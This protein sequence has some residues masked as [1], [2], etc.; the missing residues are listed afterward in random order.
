MAI[1]IVI[2]FAV[3][4]FVLHDQFDAAT[5]M[6]T[7][8]DD[9]VT[10]LAWSPQPGGPLFVGTQKGAVFRLPEG[11]APEPVTGRTKRGPI[12]SIFP[13]PS[14]DEAGAVWLDPDAGLEP[15][16]TLYRTDGLPASDGLAVSIGGSIV[17]A[18]ALSDPAAGSGP[19]L[20]TL[21]PDKNGGPAAPRGR[22]PIRPPGAQARLTAMSGFEI[23]SRRF[24][25]VVAGY[26]T[27]DVRVWD[28]QTGEA[29]KLPDAPPG[30]SAGDA[31]VHVAA[32]P[33]LDDSTNF[34]TASGNGSFAFYEARIDAATV[35]K[36][37]SVVVRRANPCRP[38]QLEMR[39]VRSGASPA[40]V[41]VNAA[42]LVVCGDGDVI[43]ARPK[44]IEDG[45]RVHAAQ[46]IV[47]ESFA[48]KDLR[49]VQMALP[50]SGQRILALQ[51]ALD[52][53]GASL[54]PRPTSQ[55]DALLGPR[56]R[57]SVAA[58]SPRGD[59]FAVA[60]NDGVIR[61][62]VL[63]DDP[64]APPSSATTFRISGHADVVTQLAISAD[65]RRLASSGIDGRLWITD[66]D[67]ARRRA[68]LL[69]YDLSSGPVGADMA[70]VPLRVPAGA[71]PAA[72]NDYIVVYASDQNQAAAED[73][74][75]RA[76]R[77][78]FSD[79]TIYRLDDLFV[80]VARFETAQAQA[81]GLARLK[82]LSRHS[83]NAYARR[84]SQWCP[85]AEDAGGM[86]RCIPQ[87]PE[88]TIGNL[89]L[90]QAPPDPA[91][92]ASPGADS[93][94][95]A[96]NVQQS[97]P[98]AASI[99]PIRTDKPADLPRVQKVFIKSLTFDTGWVGGEHSQS[100]ACSQAIRIYQPQFPG[101][102]LESA[103]SSESS[104]KE[105]IGK[106]TYRYVCKFNVF[107]MQA[108]NR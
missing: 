11:G 4:A 53:F 8:E 102:I 97:S 36:L 63:P 67:Q 19:N 104:R 44:L 72:P 1:P 64:A 55:H 43:V 33:P 27:G 96:A 3:K 103:G 85:R 22:T 107:E 50:R 49:A 31:I 94:P 40:P 60:G 76:R 54:V 92:Q 70:A 10:A 28:R 6:L 45:R 41:N 46:S 56:W 21:A 25:G 29:L 14:G 23:P 101:K 34:I 15:K 9:Q 16:D 98:A 91:S 88:A 13:S 58:L 47:F 95:P 75:T 52:Q 24:H 78:G 77:A 66:L 62:V 5:A 74:I 37:G 17:P 59:F 80:S 30:H 32:G 93:P 71:G 12:V 108:T 89:P 61:V 57:T 86:T 90:P 84:L 99:P 42:A 106:S 68:S 105:F 69:F 7:G 65:G 81:E 79:L 18:V 82:G 100:E 48:P 73:E 35:E 2:A 39:A 26:D 51:R 87:V 20:A 38:M 83:T